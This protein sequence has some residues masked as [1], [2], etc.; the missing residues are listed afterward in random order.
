VKHYSEGLEAVLLHTLD[1]EPESLLARVM[2]TTSLAVNSYHHQAVNR[3]GEG[4]R[5]SGRA[6]DGVIEGIEAVDGRQILG[7]QFHPEEC[8]ATYP[9]FQR[10][11]DWLVE[12]A[13]G[14]ASGVADRG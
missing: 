13:S 4:L 9:Q 6:R 11:F 14:S 7:V 1:I 3:V 12:E 5:I 2:Q 10:P 8:T